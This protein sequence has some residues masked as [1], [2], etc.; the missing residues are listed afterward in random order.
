MH[1]GF[2]RGR[3]FAGRTA[4]GLALCLAVS[5]SFECPVRVDG[6]LDH[7]VKII[8]PFPA[9]GTADAYTLCSIAADVHVA[10]LVNVTRARMGW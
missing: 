5:A 10:Q 4:I 6:Y 3:L 2:R 7:A 8:V 1:Y 9:G